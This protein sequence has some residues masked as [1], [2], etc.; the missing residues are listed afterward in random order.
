MTTEPVGADIAESTAPPKRTWRAR[1]LDT[2]NFLTFWVSVEVCDALKP[3]TQPGKTFEKQMGELR[4]EIARLTPETVEFLAKVWRD[5]LAGVSGDIDTTRARAG[6]L[7]AVAGF[8][9]AL[10]ALGSAATV[11]S[12]ERWATLAAAVP[13]A[14]FFIGTLWLTYGAIKVS[15]W[16]LLRLNPPPATVRGE[17]A[18]ARVEY[19]WGLLSVATRLRLRLE[20]PAGYLKDAY[21]YFA[22]TAGLLGVLMILRLG[23]PDAQAARPTPALTTATSAAPS[24]SASSPTTRAAPTVASPVQR[25]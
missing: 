24:P 2:R 14:F 6:Q 11:A 5:E 1:V 8:L 16:D 17:L 20:V 12:W 9:S 3:D 22:I 21:K 4:E 25:H 10:G 7:L 23:G 18:A 19:A 15:Q 13:L